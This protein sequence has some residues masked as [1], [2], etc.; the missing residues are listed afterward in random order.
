[1]PNNQNYFG[2]KRNIQQSN[3]YYVQSFLFPS[4]TT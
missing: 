4:E 2:F 3:I 1:M